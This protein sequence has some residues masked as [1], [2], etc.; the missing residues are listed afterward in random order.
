MIARA[1][2]REFFGLGAESDARSDKVPAMRIVAAAFGSVLVAVVATSTTAPRAEL[3]RHVDG[4]AR[5]LAS[6]SFADLGAW[7][8]YFFLES[9]GPNLDLRSDPG[10][11]L[12]ITRAGLLVAEADVP[13]RCFGRWRFDPAS[14]RP[15]RRDAVA[16]AS[17]ATGA[18]ASC[19][20]PGDPVPHSNEVAAALSIVPIP[21]LAYSRPIT[22]SLPIPLVPLN[23]DP[24]DSLSQ[25]NATLSRASSDEQQALLGCGP[26]WG[27]DCATDGINLGNAEA[28]VLMQSLIGSRGYPAPLYVPG[29]SSGG[30][31][32]PTNTFQSEMAALSFNM[33][34]LLVALSTPT[35]VTQP[36]GEV[37]PT[38]LQPADPFSTSPG[39]CS[40]RQPQ[41]CASVRD[42]YSLTMTTEPRDDDPDGASQRWIWE[43]GA[44]YRVVE[45][46]GD[47]EGYAGGRVHVLGVERSRTRAATTGIPIALFPAPD[48]AL[49]P[50]APFA[51]PA[52]GGATSSNL[53][54]AYLTIP[55]PSGAALTSVAIAA[56]MLLARS[57]SARPA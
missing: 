52:T 8:A 37:D 2:V 56:L 18:E 53:G 14:G 22:P 21:L 47:V 31:G 42:F 28:S 45:A 46:W 3:L 7:G 10:S 29:S 30:L 17:C 41:Y 26:F 32:I 13:A 57:T 24:A 48:T 16:G 15:L 51:M 23:S 40:F 44:E 6:P 27:T 54:L 1:P 35:S 38:A 55:E 43:G 9:A 34:N 20:R 19:W 12:L 39:Q 25:T 33:Q 5:R 4:D 50:D 11:L 49:D 36:G